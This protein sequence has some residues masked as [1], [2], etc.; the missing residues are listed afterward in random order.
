MLASMILLAI[1]MVYA[2]LKPLTA[3]HGSMLTYDKSNYP[4]LMHSSLDSNKISITKKTC[5]K[6]C[7]NGLS[8]KIL[9]KK[10]FIIN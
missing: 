9:P 8:H 5:A 2:H 7:V 6:Y 10:T 3:I 1:E 4:Y